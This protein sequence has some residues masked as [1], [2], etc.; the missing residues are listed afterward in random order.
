MR[1]LPSVQSFLAQDADAATSGSTEKATER[2][3]HRSRQSSGPKTSSKII[4]T[5]GSSQLTVNTQVDKTA[6]L[7]C[8][9]PAPVLAAPGNTSI[10]PCPPSLNIAEGEILG[11][12]STG[13]GPK[14]QLFSDDEDS[15]HVC[16]PLTLVR[17]G[18]DHIRIV[19]DA[20]AAAILDVPNAEQAIQDTQTLTDSPQVTHS[21]V[22][23]DLRA[24]TTTKCT[25]PE[26][27][28]PKCLKMQPT[29]SISPS[30]EQQVRNLETWHSLCDDVYVN[31][32]LVKDEFRQTES[33]PCSSSES[34]VLK[35]FHR[36]CQT[37]F[38]AHIPSTIPPPFQLRLHSLLGPKYALDGLG[39]TGFTSPFA[40]S[41]HGSMD[42]SSCDEH[43]EAAT[44]TA[45]LIL[46]EHLQED[47]RQRSG[48]NQVP[49]SEDLYITP[50]RSP[51]FDLSNPEHSE[52]TIPCFMNDSMP[53]SPVYA[54][55]PQDK[56]CVTESTLSSPVLCLTSTFKPGFLTPVP[57]KSTPQNICT[58]KCSSHHHVLPCY[59]LVDTNGFPSF[60]HSPLSDG[61]VHPNKSLFQSDN[62]SFESP[63][64][65]D[66]TKPRDRPKKAKRH[67][68]GDICH[69][70]IRRRNRNGFQS[71]VSECNTLSQMPVVKRPKLSAKHTTPREKPPKAKSKTSEF[72]P[73]KR[74]LAPGSVTP[75][76]VHVPRTAAA[77]A[78]ELISLSVRALFSP[79]QPSRYFN[80]N[81][82]LI[83]AARLSQPTVTADYCE[84]T[85]PTPSTRHTKTQL[86]CAI[87]LTSPTPKGSKRS[88]GRTLFPPEPIAT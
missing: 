46:S 76:R 78:R 2:K 70:Q 11:D 21:P 4:K 57:D 44:A 34:P 61:G 20:A 14:P 51:I 40:L 81:H 5:S 45:A 12:N 83:S 47:C 87:N 73:R 67:C 18:E 64:T 35:R 62:V 33:I 15:N 79:P 32:E 8:E 56:G 30:T 53:S 66:Y 86:L 7:F 3:R 63:Q 48:V 27:I 59:S 26:I 31:E 36:V 54:P 49:V 22:E 52:S 37:C 28:T 60:C 16:D 19:T 24:Q 29:P 13:V 10:I 50:P 84:P 6:P 25:A 58:P 88:H 55:E 17:T 85:P 9:T 69:R 43:D 72:V 41:D 1:K 42:N 23:V 75:D 68:K 39:C 80:P 71:P 65:S 38:R 82:S 74:P 77:V